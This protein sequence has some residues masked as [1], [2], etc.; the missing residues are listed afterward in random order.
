MPSTLLLIGEFSEIF[1]LNFYF[2]L[3]VSFHLDS[4]CA[5]AGKRGSCSLATNN[6]VLVK[7]NSKTCWEITKVNVGVCVC[8]LEAPPRLL[9]RPI[10]TPL[11]SM[12]MNK[13]YW[14]FYHCSH[15]YLRGGF[16]PPLDPPPP[17]PTFFFLNLC[18]Q[19]SFVKW[20][21]LFDRSSMTK[22]NIV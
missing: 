19:F 3:F 5:E 4:M 16:F 12:Q 6:Q 20:G 15:L 11:L 13:K 1:S 8:G 21:N 2:I 22:N 17:T 9:K 7:N 10:N 14:S 18:S